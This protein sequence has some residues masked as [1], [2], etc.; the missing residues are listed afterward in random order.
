[1]NDTCIFCEII[2]GRA[3]AS[4]VYRDEA[5][6]A[7]MDIRPVNAGHVLVVPVRHAAMLSELREED[8]AK[9]FP[10]AQR[11]AAALRKSGVKCEGVNFFLADGRAAGQ[12]V[13]HVHLHVFP[14]FAND[15]HHLRF[16][17][18]YFKPHTRQQIEETAER[19]RKA[20]GI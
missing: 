11:V 6:A 14:R 7:F 5:V 16:S 17:P 12:D 1:M 8:G 13:W 4:F 9:L 20:L 18:D 3:E 2:A 10:V 15:G 19:L